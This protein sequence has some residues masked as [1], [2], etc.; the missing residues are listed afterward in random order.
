MQKVVSAREYVVLGMLAHRLV[1][2]IQRQGH[3][4][5][6]VFA[7]L[8][9]FLVDAPLD[10]V[11]R[12]PGE[13]LVQEISRFHQF[14]GLVR[15]V[16][17]DDAVLH[18]SIGCHNDQQDALLRQ[19]QEFNVA[20]SGGAALGRHHHAGEARQVGQQMRSLGDK[21]LRVV[22]LQLAFQLAYFNL[23]QRPDLEQRIDEEAVAAR[24]RDPARGRVRAGDEAEFFEIRHDV[25]DAGRAQF[26]TGKPGKRARTDRLAVGNIALD[27]HFQQALCPFAGK[28]VARVHIAIL[29]CRCRNLSSTVRVKSAN[30]L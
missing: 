29:P 8:A 14:R 12:Q 17:D 6:H 26:K 11:E 24:R 20:E 23:V 9:Q 2:G 28:A 10:I 1:A 5:R 15:P 22:R 18:I 21:F 16:G 7:Q 27:E 25:A 30:V 3:Q 19:A 4:L 13:V